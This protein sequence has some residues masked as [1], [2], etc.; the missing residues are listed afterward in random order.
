MNILLNLIQ[1]LKQNMKLLQPKVIAY[2]EAT[3]AKTIDNNTVICDYFINN[4]ID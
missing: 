1:N 4:S 3:N 2:N